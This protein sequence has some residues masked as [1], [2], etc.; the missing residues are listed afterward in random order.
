MEVLA[1]DSVVADDELEGVGVD[2]D[3]AA[4]ER[5][6][7]LELDVEPVKGGAVTV[8]VTVVGGEVTVVVVCTDRVD[9]TVVTGGGVTVMVVGE[10]RISVTVAAG[11]VTVAVVGAMIVERMI[12]DEVTA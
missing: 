8:N 7:V 4:V 3:E 11:D 6:V 5:V 9:V 10:V 1:L 12:A 2:E